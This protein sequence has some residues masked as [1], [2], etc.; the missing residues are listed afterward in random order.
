M[1]SGNTNKTAINLLDCCN[2]YTTDKVVVEVL[3][4]YIKE[5]RR[6]IVYEEG[7][8]TVGE[9]TYLFCKEI[10]YY[11][12]VRG[13]S[14]QVFAEVLGALEGT[15]LD[16]IERKVKDYEQRKRAENGDIW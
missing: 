14:Y 3:V 10:K 9:L 15:K 7:A 4:P 6:Q 5:N 1:E 16:F 13:E 2:N 11:L 12:H 8:A